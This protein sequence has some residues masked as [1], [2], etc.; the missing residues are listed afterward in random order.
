MLL[1]NADGTGH[2]NANADANSNCNAK[3]MAHSTGNGHSPLT[4]GNTNGNGIFSA[5]HPVSCGSFT[6]VTL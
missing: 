2:G 1:I 3:V 6:P 5:I 4:R